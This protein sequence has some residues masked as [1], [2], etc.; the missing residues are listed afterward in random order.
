MGKFVRMTGSAAVALI[1]CAACA[2]QFEA[3]DATRIHK[4]RL[5]GFAEP[6]YQALFFVLLNAAPV[7]PEGYDEF[8]VLMA[9][10]NLHLGAELKAAVTQALR[11]D[12]YEVVEDGSTSADAVL[13]L[14]IRGWEPSPNPLYASHGGDYEPEFVIGIQMTDST[15]KRTLFSGGYVYR[16]NLIKPRT[17][18]A[19]DPKYYF[20]TAKEL[21]DNPQ[22]AAQGFRAAEPL[23]AQSIESALRKS[24]S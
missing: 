23:I 9:R 16:D 19:P 1:L 5:S 11:N 24:G 7:K 14:Q 15:T 4:I 13:D 17:G 20:K 10:Q 18:S 3:A 6:T 2:T 21:F 12:G 22:L 8:S